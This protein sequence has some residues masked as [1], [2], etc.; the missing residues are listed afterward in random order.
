MV[1][2][3]MYEVAKYVARTEHL[4]SACRSFAN[5]KRIDALLG[6]PEENLLEAAKASCTAMFEVPR[7]TKRKA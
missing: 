2:M 1:A 7:R 4:P 3:K 5:A 6:V